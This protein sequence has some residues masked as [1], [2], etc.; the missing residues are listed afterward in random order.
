MENTQPNL[1][2]EYRIQGVV[3]TLT[4]QKI[5]EEKQ[6]QG[7]EDS[8]LPLIEQNEKIRLVLDYSNVKFLTS[9]VLGLLIRVSKRINEAEGQLKL[10]CIAPKIMEIFR[11][12]QLNKIFDIHDSQDKALE[13]LK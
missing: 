11:I 6:I 12:T 3:A 9:S 13:A 4:D 7:L 5:L 1:A 10:C 8:L 2:I